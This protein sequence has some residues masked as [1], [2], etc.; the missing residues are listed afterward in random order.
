MTT[1]M[2]K[3]SFVVIVVGLFLQYSP[4]R[5]YQQLKENDK[6][7]HDRH[8]NIIMDPSWNIRDY[9]RDTHAW[10]DYEQQF[11]RY[12]TENDENQQ[13][14]K[15]S[16]LVTDMVKL[17]MQRNPRHHH[18][19]YHHHHKEKLRGTSSSSGSSL[20]SGGVMNNNFRPSNLQMY[21]HRLKQTQQHEAETQTTATS[22][23][24]SAT[25]SYSGKPTIFQRGQQR[26][27]TIKHRTFTYNCTT[28][29]ITRHNRWLLAE[30]V[31][32][33][34]CNQL[35]G[36]YS[37]V[38]TAFFYN[39]SLI[40]D[41]LF[42][43]TSFEHPWPLQ[44]NQW[45]RL[46]FSSFFDWYHFSNFWRMRGVEMIE[47]HQYRRCPESPDKL[48]PINLIRDP[49]SWP[50]DFQTKMKMLA[51]NNV[52]NPLPENIML[53]L[54]SPQ[55]FLHFAFVF[56]FPALLI[57]IFLSLQPAPLLVKYIRLIQEKI[58]DLISL[59]NQENKIKEV[60]YVATHLRLEN[61][62]QSRYSQLDRMKAHSKAIEWM[63]NNHTCLST[64]PRDP[65]NP[66][67][68]LHPP[69]LFISSGL[70]A[71]KVDLQETLKS[72][73]NGSVT[74]EAAYNV[75]VTSWQDFTL[76]LLYEAGFEQVFTK[77]T[78]IYE[79]EKQ[80][81]STQANTDSAEESI[82]FISYHALLPEQ[83]ALIDLYLARYA[84]C[85]CSA[86]SSSSFSYWVQRMK[87]LA[88]HKHLHIAKVNLKTYGPHWSFGLW[89]A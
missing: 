51:F 49:P 73:R 18:H 46:P 48:K 74:K 78:I 20:G 21:Y 6:N 63:I 69:P 37:Y 66:N 86:Y 79:L 83:L 36:I 77:E 22:T 32:T 55:K 35:S 44:D 31:P 72:F 13:K 61:D 64:W 47:G 23:S 42:S 8:Q 54:I 25:T 34:L 56:E 84:P 57:D 1:G 33:G 9:Q 87:D 10:I 16:N 26:L 67:K 19:H 17:A 28:L 3:L 29:P 41:D 45:T 24:T 53:R 76:Y 58:L 88:N 15:L 39:S 4:S 2:W 50:F 85:F 70:W 71:E 89:G 38:A 68:L 14:Q 40:V 59:Y 52:S 7:G 12:L 30:S 5:A 82:D 65:H 81:Q 62:F 11:H 75:S 60:Y 80:S 27:K 43:R